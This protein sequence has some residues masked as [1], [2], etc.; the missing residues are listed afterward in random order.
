MRAAGIT[1]L[2]EPVEILEVD[3]LAPPSEDEVLIDVAAAGIGNWDEL[4]RIGSWRIGGQAPMALG[5]EAAGTVVAVGSRVA[6]VRD[7]DEVMTHPLPLRRHGTWAGKV[8]APAATLAP[9]PS[10]ASWEASGA[11]PI[12]ALT[13]AQALDEALGIESGG[14]VVVNGAGGVTGG[15]LVQLAAARGARVIATAS[16]KKAE[17]IRGHGAAEVLDYHGDWPAVVR[18]I[19]GGAPKAVN[20]APGQAA[21]TLK[22]V[23]DGGRLATITGDPPREERGVAV[24]DVYVRPDG[25]QL[26][27]LAELLA[28][29]TLSVP[30][31]SVRPLEQA[32]QALREVVAGADGAI[33]LSLRT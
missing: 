31:A 19:T 18:E 14:W 5:T 20:A 12:P 13:A 29:G 8:L 4:V 6:E 16:A 25:R 7:G 32:A 9:R 10:A 22:A 1:A 28:C 2:G 21:T 23:A 26:S 27:A 15:L 17:R 3:E 24:S 30:I 11:F 33:V